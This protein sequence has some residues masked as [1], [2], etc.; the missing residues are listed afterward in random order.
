MHAEW[1]YKRVFKILIVRL[2]VVQGFLLAL[3]GPFL[4]LTRP[5]LL[6]FYTGLLVGAFLFWLA[7]AKPRKTRLGG[8]GCLLVTVFLLISGV[9]GCASWLGRL[10]GIPSAQLAEHASALFTLFVLLGP[11]TY[12][13]EILEQCY[14]QVH[15]AP[16]IQRDLGFESDTNT[17]EG[18]WPTGRRFLFFTRIQ[19]DGAMD[20]AGLRPYDIVVDGCTFTEF[21]QRLEE[22]RGGPPATITVA[23]WSDTGPVSERPTRQISVRL[24]RRNYSVA[25]E[26]ELGFRCE[27]KYVKE[28]GNWNGVVV[29]MN[30]HRGGLMARAGFQD[31]DIL[32][33]V[34]GVPA[35]FERLEQARGLA[36]VTLEVVPWLDPPDIADRPVREFFVEIPPAT[37]GSLGDRRGAFRYEQA[38]QRE[39]G[40]KAGW[41][42]LPHRG[43]W[44]GW[45][46]VEDLQ[47]QGVLA[48]AGFQNKDILLEGF[49]WSTRWHKARGQE[50][51]SVKVV[52]WME[53]APVRERAHRQLALSIPGSDNLL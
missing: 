42:C 36:P 34:G 33:N 20:Q 4:D 53:P 7:W 38:L 24:P 14:Y 37:D 27:V 12:H 45:P 22:S 11:I 26:R 10:A 31:R 39:L 29:V 25:L 13:W 21:W 44:H 17:L 52:S 51:I 35:F 48:R 1:T 16:Q 41:E 15:L 28:S 19:P 43:E 6:L 2:F 40:F 50:P 18:T 5:D 32:L 23:S 47:P 9:L 46:T 49:S 3:F 8:A 30:L